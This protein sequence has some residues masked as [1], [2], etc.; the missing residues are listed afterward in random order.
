LVE[1]PIPVLL[2]D[3][4]L[5][6]FPPSLLPELLDPPTA[7]APPE[8]LVETLPPLEE[9]PLELLRVLDAPPEPVLL[10]LL[11]TLAPPEPVLPP[12]PPSDDDE[13]PQSPKL[14]RPSTIRFADRRLNFGAMFS[15]R[16]RITT[17]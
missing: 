7:D 5:L 13:Q 16:E 14:V 10:L 8:T 2:V 15:P 9:E 6:D 12:A 17:Q 11:I 1:P 3:E 4:V